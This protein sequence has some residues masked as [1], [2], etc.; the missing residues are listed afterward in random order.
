MAGIE[1]DV[2]T[3]FLVRL[4]ESGEVPAELVDEFSAALTEQKLPNADELAAMYAAGSGD[5]LT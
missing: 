3:T 1:W 5:R 4:K 2:L